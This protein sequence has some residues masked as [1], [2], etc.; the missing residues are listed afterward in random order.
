MP[1]EFHCEHCGKHVRAADEHAGK[2]AKCPSCHQP[3]YVPEPVSDEDVLRIAPL[4]PRDEQERSRLLRETADLTRKIRSDKETGAEPGPAK[5]AAAASDDI[6]TRDV[7]VEPLIIEYVKLMAKGD[8]AAAEALA[9]DIRKHWT[10]AEAVMQRLTIDEIGH[11]ALSSI[12]RPVLVGFF[13]RL[14][15]KK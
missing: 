7:D 9:R 13:K 3:V 5:R 14:R 12:P 4:D 8:L 10:A 2:T 15:E 6:P 11:P 1:I